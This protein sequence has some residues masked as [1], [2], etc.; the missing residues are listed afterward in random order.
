MEDIL[1]SQPPYHTNPSLGFQARDQPV[2]TNAEKLH[3]SHCCSQDSN[4]AQHNLFG[5]HSLRRLYKLLP[6][7][8]TGI[9]STHKS[10]TVPSSRFT[11][12]CP[13]A[14]IWPHTFLEMLRV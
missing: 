10:H 2:Q 1:H 9:I 13:S 3:G 14:K 8:I 6:D 11:F 12:L 4:K 7:R 5:H